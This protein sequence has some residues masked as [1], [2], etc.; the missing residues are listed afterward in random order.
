MTILGDTT[1]FSR[2]SP[3]D[4]HDCTD[5]IKTK[6]QKNLVKCVKSGLLPFTISDL[7]RPRGS[8]RPCLY[9]LPKTHKDGVPLR[10][11]LSMIGSSL[12][13]VVKWLTTIL[14]PVLD[15]YRI[16]CI[17]DSFEFSSFIKAYSWTDKFMCSLDVCSLFNCL[18]LETIDHRAIGLMNRVFAYGLGYRGSI[19]GR[20]IPKTQ[21]M[22]LD[23]AL[24]NT[25]H[26]KVWIKG[27]VEQSR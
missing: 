23:A 2:L 22:V 11:I 18:S 5:Y 7:I 17:K 19:P 13:K 20:V 16:Y 15:Y 6:F 9:G 14:Q 3:I 1:K 12:H 27:K 10:P 25:Q 21:K 8:I 4:K 26:Y 24:L